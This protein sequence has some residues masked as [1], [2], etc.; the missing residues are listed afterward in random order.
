MCSWTGFTRILLSIFAPIFT[1]ILFLKFSFF[2]GFCVA[3]ISELLWFHR[4]NYV[5]FLLFLLNG[6]F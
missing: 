1:S 5:V 6:I 2:V 4:M 3:F